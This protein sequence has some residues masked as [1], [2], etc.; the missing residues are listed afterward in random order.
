MLEETNGQFSYTPG[1]MHQSEKNVVLY[2]RRNRILFFFIKH[3][4]QTLNLT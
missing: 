4:S 2:L 3:R 1:E